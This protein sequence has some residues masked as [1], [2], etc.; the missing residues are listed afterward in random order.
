MELGYLEYAA[1]R[2]I[3]CSVRDSFLSRVRVRSVYCCRESTI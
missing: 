1:L 2:V 3:S